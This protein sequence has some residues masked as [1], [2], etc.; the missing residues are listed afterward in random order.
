VALSFC[1]SHLLLNERLLI[2]VYGSFFACFAYL[3]FSCDSQPPYTNKQGKEVLYLHKFHLRGEGLLS[4]RT[5]IS[6]LMLMPRHY[7]SHTP[8]S[9]SGSASGHTL[10]TSLT[11][12]IWCG[13]GTAT[14][15]QEASSRTDKRHKGL[16]HRYIPGAR[17]RREHLEQDHQVGTLKLAVGQRWHCCVKKCLGVHV[18]LGVTKGVV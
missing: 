9:G 12:S 14:W 11:T 3:D 4:T 10:G 6:P 18:T 13:K 2:A 16:E 5:D 1:V 15:T 8:T 7:S 17:E